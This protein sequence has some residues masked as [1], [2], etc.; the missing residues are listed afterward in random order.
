MPRLVE[1]QGL[2]RP[3]RS[4][5]EW[6]NWFQSNRHRILFQTL[7]LEQHRKKRDKKR[8]SYMICRNVSFHPSVLCRI[9][10]TGSDVSLT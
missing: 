1:K 6:Q 7:Y 5:S 9:E 10:H 2:Q 3:A 8:N 4:S